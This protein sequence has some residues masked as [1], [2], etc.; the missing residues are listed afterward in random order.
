MASKM[1]NAEAIALR[2]RVFV[3]KARAEGHSNLIDTMCLLEAAETLGL[4][5]GGDYSLRTV[6]MIA[7]REAAA[8]G[9]TSLLDL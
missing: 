7:R 9:E 2:A 8:M 3:R 6:K 4:H 5:G 1:E